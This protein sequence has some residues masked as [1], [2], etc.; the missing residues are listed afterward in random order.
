MNGGLAR[1]RTGVQGFAVLCVTTPPRGLPPDPGPASLNKCPLPCQ[2]KP[3][4]TGL[5][6]QHF[7]FR[8]GL[9]LASAQMN[10]RLDSITLAGPCP[11]RHYAKD[12]YDPSSSFLLFH[13][14]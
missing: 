12:Q 1:N 8:P 7:L 13:H 11:P 6:Y 9:R 3:V 14:R 4:K 10:E 5:S 2:A